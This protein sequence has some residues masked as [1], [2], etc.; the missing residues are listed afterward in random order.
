M[1]FLVAVSRSRQGSSPAHAHI[2]YAAKFLPASGVESRT[3]PWPRT[4]HLH[5]GI[6]L[7]KHLFDTISLGILRVPSPWRAGGASTLPFSR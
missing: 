7:L 6:Y 2:T 3:G 1:I 4:Q 5:L